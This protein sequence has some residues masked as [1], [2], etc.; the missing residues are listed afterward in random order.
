MVV[1]HIDNHHHKLSDYRLDNLQLLTPYQNTTKERKMSTKTLK[2]PL[3][4]DELNAKL[5]RFTELYEQA[6]LEHDAKG[7]HLQR[8]NIANTRARMRYVNE[9]QQL[10]NKSDNN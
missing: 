1:D 5:I 3:T 8:C 9:I 7:A 6:K 2:T 4:I 10:S